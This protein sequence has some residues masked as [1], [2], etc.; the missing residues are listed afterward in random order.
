M[1]IALPVLTLRQAFAFVGPD[2]DPERNIARR[3]P[4]VGARAAGILC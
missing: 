2:D 3:L 4:A 1:P